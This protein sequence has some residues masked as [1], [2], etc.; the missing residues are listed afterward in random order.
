M[1]ISMRW[2]SFILVL[3]LGEAG[4]GTALGSSL[5][6]LDDGTAEGLRGFGPGAGNSVFYANEFT[7]SPNANVIDSISIAY[8]SPLQ[9]G[10]ATVGTPVVL[11]LFKDANGLAT[12]ETPVLMTS[13]TTTVMSPDTNTFIT[14]P[15][16]PTA[17]TGNFFVGA[18]FSNLPA[19]GPFPM[20][21]DTST[22]QN[23]SY[24]SAFTN[25]YTTGLGLL[26]SLRYNPDNT[27][28]VNLYEFGPA[29]DGNFLI[30]ADGVPAAAPEP[31]SLA[32]CGVALLT[33]LGWKWTR[34]RD[35]PT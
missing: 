33:G 14:V 5:Y 24:S 18:P 15:I 20:G 11:F 25:T 7:A 13:V 34:G 21:F 9:P 4:M 10:R 3:G 19:S 27:F 8:G 30:R 6:S 2:I 32:I 26:S 17:V 23:R 35:L 31:S 16:P 1:K 29:H 28:P 22:P 12:P